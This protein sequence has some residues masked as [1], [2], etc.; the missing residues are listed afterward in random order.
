M[1]SIAP[2][3]RAARAALAEALPPG[4]SL[5][6]AERL[7]EVGSLRLHSAVPL[8]DHGSSGTFLA[9]L[10]LDTRELAALVSHGVAML[11]A[12]RR[13]VTR[14]GSVLALLVEDQDGLLAELDEL[15]ALEHPCSLALA[16]S[17]DS[18]AGWLANL[19]L[20]GEPLSAVLHDLWC[21]RLRYQGP[22]LGCRVAG[23]EALRR[24]CWSC[25]AD[26]Q[27][28][29]GLVFPDRPVRDWTSPA[30]AYYGQLLAPRRLD[31]PARS[32]LVQ[33]V[34]SWRAQGAAQL[35]PLRRR[36]SKTA[37][38][39]YLGAVCPRCGALQGDF[40]LTEDR[41]Q[42]LHHLQARKTG[43]LSYRP[44]EVDV[45]ERLIGHLACGGEINSHCRFLGW[46]RVDA[47][48]E[49]PR[50]FAARFDRL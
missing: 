36:Y 13:R 44:L 48:E 26:L 37:D 22:D 5:L 31:E 34:D 20:G 29:T 42:H 45:T 50:V 3:R 46:R 23:V 4:W 30:W 16:C 39:A 43:D 17:P 32:A 33:A 27:A 12:L 14:R 40:P 9:I 38:L 24:C 8:A 19:G 49:R 6:P 41:M 21:G 1:A 10:A 28:V 18:E 25:K 15:L 7:P 2:L 35:T 11:A 47:P